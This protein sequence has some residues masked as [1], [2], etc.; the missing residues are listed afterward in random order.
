MLQHSMSEFNLTSTIVFI[1]LLS[2]LPER[3]SG[4][5]RA[6]LYLMMRALK[7]LLLKKKKKRTEKLVRVKKTTKSAQLIRFQN[8]HF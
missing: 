7:H 5:C 2:M 4:D 1:I 3:D 8:I 6:T